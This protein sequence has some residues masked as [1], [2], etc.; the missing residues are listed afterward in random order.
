MGETPGPQRANTPK[1]PELGLI[2]C[3]C[4]LEFLVHL[5]QG[6]HVF[7]ECWAPSS[8]RG[9]LG[10]Q[11]TGSAPLTFP[12]PVNG[13]GKRTAAET[14]NTPGSSCPREGPGHPHFHI[15][16]HSH[17]CAHRS[18][19]LPHTLT[20]AHMCSHVQELVTPRHGLPAPGVAQETS[21][22]HL[23]TPGL[24][25]QRGEGVEELGSGRWGQRESPTPPPPPQS[26]R[27][28]EM[29]TPPPTRRPLLHPQAA[30]PTETPEVGFISHPFSWWAK[31]RLQEAKMLVQPRQADPG[32][33]RP[34]AG[35]ET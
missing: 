8:G 9:T 15:R 26:A 10:A 29:P 18:S 21:R 5:E 24:M 1:D 19:R 34:T 13:L 27:K 2:L 12:E 16:S 22:H 23:G 32:A 17:D 28:G 31:L 33:P 14:T 7:L 6:V 4:H 3:R 20:R 11:H 30:L 35:P 25:R